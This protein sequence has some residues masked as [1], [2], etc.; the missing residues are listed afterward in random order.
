MDR[1]WLTVLCAAR[2]PR[3]Y[4]DE[5]PWRE[6]P[7]HEWHS[8][9]SSRGMAT[10]SSVLCGVAFVRTNAIPQTPIQPRA[11]CTDTDWR[12]PGNRPCE[13]FKEAIVIDKNRHGPFA[14]RVYNKHR[15]DCLHRTYDTVTITNEQ[16]WEVLLWW[17]ELNVADFEQFRKGNRRHKLRAKLFVMPV[18]ECMVAQ[19]TPYIWDLRDFWSKGGLI[20]PIR[21]GDERRHTL[22]AD[23]IALLQEATEVDDLD[24]VDM[25]QIA[26]ETHAYPQRAFG[27]GYATGVA[28][29]P[30][31]AHQLGG[32]RLGPGS[33]GVGTD[34]HTDANPATELGAAGGTGP[35]PVSP[36]AAGGPPCNAR[37]RLRRSL[38][39]LYSRGQPGEQN[40]GGRRACHNGHRHDP[41]RGSRQGRGV[42]R[43][44][45]ARTRMAF[46]RVSQGR[47]REE[48]KGALCF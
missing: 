11:P 13:L 2:S 45:T 25:M 42:D 35:E 5:F 41:R 26:V 22:H 6:L 30:S 37:V 39:R 32:S 18:D 16:F 34:G 21:A 31:Y 47:A 46:F 29:D 48:G 33:S 20:R 28:S 14:T 12:P 3:E 7:D 36:M 24:I 8:A 40:E 38:R 43:T 1:W 4:A 19:A 9:M 23:G 44:A 15:S 17:V 10:E 27:N